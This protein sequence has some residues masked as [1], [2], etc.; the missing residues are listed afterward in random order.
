MGGGRIV[1]CNDKTDVDWLQVVIL[2]DEARAILERANLGH[3]VGRGTIANTLGEQGID[4]APERG[5]HTS[6]S[7]FLEAH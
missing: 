4:P 3:E 6:W 5:K 7:S 2:D 1:A